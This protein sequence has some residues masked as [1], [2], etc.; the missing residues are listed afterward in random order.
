MQPAAQGQ[1]GGFANMIKR[2]WNGPEEE[3]ELSNMQ[4][5]RTETDSYDARKNDPYSRG[6]AAG[7]PFRQEYH[8]APSAPDPSNFEAGTGESTVISKGTV[9]TGN[10][11]S[12]GNIEM[13]GA[14]TGNITTAGKVK[15]NGQQ[16]GDV[17]GSSV[18]LADCAVKGNVSA[19]D[20]ILVDSNSVIVGDIK[21]GAL[22]FDGKIKGN[23]HV[24]SNVT[25]KGNAVVIGDVTST[26]I[27]VEN[28]ARLQ[29]KVQIYDGSIEEI[30][31]PDPPEA[32]APQP[33]A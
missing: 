27:T 9:I 16:N 32:A 8:N 4:S 19:S 23:I 11:K 1:A 28:G 3:G 24:M 22:T 33:K 14:V 10:I 2:I 21:C 20:T 25:C 29:G 18:N 5:A 15:I 7:R 17:Q 6:E 30:D 31:V 12:D 26:T 13:Y